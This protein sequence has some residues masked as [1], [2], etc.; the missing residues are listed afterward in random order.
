MAQGGGGRSASEYMEFEFAHNFTFGEI[1]EFNVN[2]Q[3]TE[4]FLAC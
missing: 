4:R 1:T 2:R 3:E